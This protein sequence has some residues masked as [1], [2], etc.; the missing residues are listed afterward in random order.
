MPAAR[1][2]GDFKD[3]IDTYKAAGNTVS[4]DNR[5]YKLN[6][7]IILIMF[8]LRKHK[9]GN[10]VVSTDE[11]NRS[12]LKKAVKEAKRNRLKFFCC[13]IYD[14]N[15]TTVFPA[16]QEYILSIECFDYFLKSGQ[17]TV[18]L[19]ANYREVV[20]NTKDIYRISYNGTSMAFVKRNVFDKYLEYFDNRPYLGE[21]VYKADKIEYRDGEW[22]KGKTL[23]PADYPCNLL[24]HGAPGTGKSSMIQ[25]YFETQN[26]DENHYQRVTFYE[27]YSYGAFVGSYKPIM[28]TVSKDVSIS[29][30]SNDYNGEIQGKQVVYEF[31]PGPFSQILLKAYL[32]IITKESD[33]ENY[34]L[35]I[36]EINRAKAASVFGDMFQLLDRKNGTSIY[37]T[38]PGAEFL[39]WFNDSISMITGNDSNIKSLKIPPNMYIW[40]TMNSSD[41][42]VFPLDTAFKRRWGY[43]YKDVNAVSNKIIKL[44]K[45]DDVA[46]NS[47]DYDWD[48]FRK[49]I[50]IFIGKHFDED[51]CIGPGYFSEE[52]MEYI[53]K[54]TEAVINGD[55]T[56]DLNNPLVDK[57]FSYLRQDVFRNN[58]KM[59]FED[60]FTSM[61]DIRQAVKKGK[62]LTEITKLTSNDF[63]IATAP[64]N[65]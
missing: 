21:G 48:N 47:A 20:A 42:G 7:D 38:T 22:L 32:Q 3:W 28:D 53:A 63:V 33:I 31:V 64:A 6:N 65:Q 36:E 37:E 5:I 49:G 55:E 60:S 10:L 8:S 2:V 52:E 1:F 50:N 19:T 23:L 39:K 46:L 26:I 58:P 9:N 57:L 29:S 18:T 27:D 13:A 56:S 4:R 45:V 51:K 17:S 35:V 59:F 62:K 24:I 14:K 12:Q 40:A 16:M 34:Y 25:K 44:I 54:Y 41:Q 30:N 43:I 61:S 11:D 15:E